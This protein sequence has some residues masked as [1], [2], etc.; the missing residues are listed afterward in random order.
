MT[1]RAEARMQAIRCR[2]RK[3]RQKQENR[4]LSCLT[5]CSLL[6]VTAIYT[7]FAN[8]QALGIADVTDGYSAVLLR[9]GVSA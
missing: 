2:T 9:N 5:A 3:Y 8:V 1:G 7:L 6:L 4:K